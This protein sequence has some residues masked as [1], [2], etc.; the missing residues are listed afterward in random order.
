MKVW[1]LLTEGTPRSMYR[2]KM[3][4][5]PLKEDY[6]RESLLL[7]GIG[8]RKKIRSGRGS[9]R[10]LQGMQKRQSLWEFLY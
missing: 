5:K 8:E 3:K 4:P 9:Y 6:G 7:L 1:H 2:R 10:L